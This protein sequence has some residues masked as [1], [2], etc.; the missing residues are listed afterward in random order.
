MS[1]RSAQVL[2]RNRLTLR[3]EHGRVCTCFVTRHTKCRP[4][5][6]M[7]PQLL[8][9]VVSVDWF[10]TRPVVDLTSSMTMIDIARVGSYSGLHKT[11]RSKTEHLYRA[12]THVEPLVFPPTTAMA[13]LGTSTSRHIGDKLPLELTIDVFLIRSDEAQVPQILSN[14][15]Q[16]T[17]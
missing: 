15:T 17:P 2:V 11:C 6:T 4:L 5:T 12:R 3:T 14:A 7:L 9:R 13:F 10:N 8:S 16:N 1:G